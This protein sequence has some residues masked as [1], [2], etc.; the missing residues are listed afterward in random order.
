MCL[1]GVSP[2]LVRADPS[3]PLGGGAE[4]EGAA[5]PDLVGDRRHGCTRFSQQSAASAIRHV[6]ANDG[7]GVS[8]RPLLRDPLNAGGSI[9]RPE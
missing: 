1:A 4:S 8:L 2:M 6:V 7:L 9:E 5:V 3:R